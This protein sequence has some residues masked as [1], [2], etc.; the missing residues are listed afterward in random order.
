M[1]T[2]TECLKQIIAAVAE[3]R[4]RAKETVA[5]LFAELTDEQRLE[6]MSHYC[7]GCGCADTRCPCENDE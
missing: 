1:I 5:D 6:I 4:E 7:L 2:N 3:Q